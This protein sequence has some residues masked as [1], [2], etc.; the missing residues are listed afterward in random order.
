MTFSLSGMRALK[1]SQLNHIRSL[2]QP[3]YIRYRPIHTPFAL[4]SL[5]K[6]SII[7]E[8]KKASPTH[9]TLRQVAPAEQALLYEKAGARA[10]S[11][12]CDENYFQG[13]W[14]DLKEVTS[15]LD[16]PVLCKEFIFYPEQIEL[17]FNYGADAVLLINRLLSFEE[18]DY[19]YDFTLEKGMTPVVEI[20]SSDEIER[21]LALEPECIMVNMRNLQT[22]TIDKETACKALK[23]IPGSIPKIS[24]SGIE[25]VQDILTIR[26]TTETNIFLVGSALMKS[27]KP[28][29]L[30]REWSNV[31]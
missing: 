24:A 11:V 29:K 3:R 15:C 21:V 10:V 22:L 17:A 19:L 16:I 4:A 23:R 9:G 25:N 7:A 5:P 6:T 18:I 20:H 8:V 2:L 14:N 30:I 1:K 31:H 28:D 12:L 26:K 27:N 13:G